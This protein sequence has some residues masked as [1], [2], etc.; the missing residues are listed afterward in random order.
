MA[1]SKEIIYPTQEWIDAWV[2]SWLDKNPNKKVSDFK[3]LEEKA[4]E[5]WWDKQVEQNN[6]TPFDLTKEQEKASKEARTTTSTES[7]KRKGSYKFEKKAKK[8]DAEK[9]EI[10]EKFYNFAKEFT[11]NCEIVNENREISFVFNE[12]HYS[13]TLTKHRTPKK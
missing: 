3:E 1:K 6:P 2:D 7:K 12:N 4:E 10:V 11:E 8:K 9:I 13:L 5:V